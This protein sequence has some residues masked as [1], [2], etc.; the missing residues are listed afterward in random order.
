M[1]TTDSCSGVVCE[2][3]GTPVK[4]LGRCVC[5]CPRGYTGDRCQRGKL[6]NNERVYRGQVSKG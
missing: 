3:G 5:S 4:E 6:E 2:N 1:M